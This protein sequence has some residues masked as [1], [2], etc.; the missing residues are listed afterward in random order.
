MLPFAEIGTARL[1]SVI[2]MGFAVN[3]VLPF[4]LGELVRTFVLRNSDGV[5]IAATLASIL[6]ERVLD[7]LVLC[8]LLGFAALVVPFDGWLAAL[9]SVAWLGIACGCLGLVLLF[10]VPRRW[11]RR[12]MDGTVAA[13]GRLSE[14]LGRLVES[15]RGGMRAVETPGAMTVVGALSL[16][17][18]IAELGLYYLLMI[19]FGFNSGVLSL[20]A[21]MVAANLATVLPSSPGY[22]GTFDVPLQSVLADSFGVATSLASSFTLFVHAALL[23][24]VTIVGLVLL[25]REDLSIRALGRGRVELRS[26][27]GGKAAS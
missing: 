13:A 11:L 9:G 22:V 19:G 26:A 27:R 21:G 15:F 5:P 20:V 16:A 10:V 23:V 2:L 7:V 14:K 24:P 18:W 12:L 1:F 3:N 6:L 8:L 17:C 25:S 4:R